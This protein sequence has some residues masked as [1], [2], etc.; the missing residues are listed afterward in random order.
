[1]TP[2][3]PEDLFETARCAEVR[4]PDDTCMIETPGPCGVVIFGASGDLAKRKLLPSLYNLMTKGHLPGEFFV[5]CVAME[6]GDDESY[7]RA[8]RDAVSRFQP[9]KFSEETWKKFADRVH[10]ISG[11]F[12]DAGLYSSLRGR[13]E[14]LDRRHG[15]QSNRIFYCAIPPA[16]YECVI[17]N[18]GVAGLSVEDGGYT[19]LCIEKPFGHDL[20]SS[21]RL[22]ATL[23][24]HFMEH[25]IYRLDHYL[26]KE[27]VQNILM[28][29]FANSIFEPLWN[30]RY[31]DH[32]QITVSETLGVEHRAGYYDKAGVLRDMFQNHLMQLLA[33]TAMEPPS[34]FEAD[35]V[36]DEKNKVFRSIRPF[37]LDKL[38]E[39]IVVGQ[40]GAGRIN[41][42][43]IPAYRDEP[44]VP[45]D[46]TTPT[47][48][49][50]AVFIDNWR[51][52]G[53]P[54]LLRSG[55]RLAVRKAEIA[56][57]FRQVPHLMFSNVLR[58][59]I[60]ANTL[61][62]RVQPDE[63]ISLLFQT[64]QPESRDCLR[65]VLMDFSYQKVSGLDAYE[66]V[67]L[68]CMGGDQM[69]F[70]REDGEEQTWSLLTPVIRKLESETRPELF[71]NY[72]AGS[73]GPGEI[74]TLLGRHWRQW[75]PL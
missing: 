27:N 54:F 60:A 41:G 34:T 42:Q 8:M 35:C 43:G 57:H 25:Q 71:P 4:Q 24:K 17:E 63:G 68:D 62:L 30:R 37:S 58:N 28:F 21:R 45:A 50:M 40:Y 9:E 3:N 13:L 5:L 66:R 52:S 59:D 39:Q 32:V 31:I 55:K 49:A 33:L 72:A 73:D 22:N 1:M 70:V 56:I 15:T 51:W 29:R 65:P 23:K 6:E 38:H 26:A 69:L 18:L 53:V 46:S 20:E 19:H 10:Y 7:R 61:V 44:G 14:Q 2:K 12:E 16:V 67:L 48:A 11:R 75:R 74:E 47:Y 36:R 64:K